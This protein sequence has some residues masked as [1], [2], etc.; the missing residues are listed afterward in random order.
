MGDVLLTLHTI[1]VM[2]SISGHWYYTSRLIEENVIFLVLSIE[3]I[4]I[5]PWIVF[6]GLASDASIAYF[7]LIYEE[8]ANHDLKVLNRAFRHPGQ[9]DQVKRLVSPA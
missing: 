3:R 4:N 7:S 1:N 8:E 2:Q 9:P 6:C 5:D